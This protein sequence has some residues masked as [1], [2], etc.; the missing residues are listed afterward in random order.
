MN[1]R[2]LIQ[3]FLTLLPTIIHGSYGNNPNAEPYF[4][5]RAS[6]LT[7]A[8]RA[9]GTNPYA[10]PYFPNKNRRAV[11]AA[12]ILIAQS[13]P[14]VDPFN[15]PNKSL[16]DHL[17]WTAPKAPSWKQNHPTKERNIE[18]WSNPK[19]RIPIERPRS[20]H[21][22]SELSPLSRDIFGANIMPLAKN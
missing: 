19:N 1:Q 16:S 4:P 6:I 12:K 20:R 9:V 5:K 22:T 14:I 7:T 10:E 3:A 21:E 8:H 2:V 15:D 11:T 13:P 17:G 18:P